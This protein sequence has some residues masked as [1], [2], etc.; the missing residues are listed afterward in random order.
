MRVVAPRTARDGVEVVQFSCSSGNLAIPRG[1][2]R[3]APL[4]DSRH[5]HQSSSEKSYIIFC[6]Q[7]SIHSSRSPPPPP[8]SSSSS[9]SQPLPYFCRSG[10]TLFNGN[11]CRPDDRSTGRSVGRSVGRSL[12]PLSSSDSL[13]PSHQAIFLMDHSLG[14]LCKTR[15]SS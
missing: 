3:N 11:R 2:T 7:L 12:L 9:S 4:A 13:G 1:T 15:P 5:V 6:S 14:L 8:P 10:V